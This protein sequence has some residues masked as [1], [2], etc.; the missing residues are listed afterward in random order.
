MKIGARIRPF[1]AWEILVKI[2]PYIC[3]PVFYLKTNRSV[4]VTVSGETQLEVLP[5]H[6]VSPE[7]DGVL[8]VGPGEQV[9]GELH[10]PLYFQIIGGVLRDKN[11]V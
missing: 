10:G 8:G 6:V 3:P 9:L 1:N 7:P 11:T 4:T 2:L 5:L